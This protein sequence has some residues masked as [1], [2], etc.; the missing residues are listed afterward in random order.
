MKRKLLEA[1][2]QNQSSNPA[3]ASEENTEDLEDMLDDLIW[4]ISFFTK[5]IITF[6]LKILN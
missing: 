2:A 4:A 6:D 5:S 1:A 3:A